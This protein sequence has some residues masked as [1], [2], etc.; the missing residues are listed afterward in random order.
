M[1]RLLL[2][3]VL[4]S[5]CGASSLAA[6]ASDPL[7]ARR[8]VDTANDEV[9]MPEADDSSTAATLAD[10]SSPLVL[11]LSLYVV[12]D[13]DGGER[14]QRSSARTVE[15]VE[16]I[17][18]RIREIW[19][20]AGVSFDPVRVSTIT[21]PG[22]VI[23]DLIAGD[24]RP[25]IAGAGQSFAVPDAGVING[26]YVPF[27][28]GANGFT[29]LGSRIFFVTD[30]PS[31]HDERVS[32]HEIGHILG[33]H[34]VVDDATRLMFSGTNGTA[35]TPTETTVARYGAAGILDRVR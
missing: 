5:S 31:V 13:A 10:D 25:F 2:L 3:A 16:E 21:V 24:A 6:P 23:D 22:G 27:V 26:F 15:G 30:R 11:S 7:P 33:L 34:H 17:A 14:S 12:Q 20:A 1:Y 19:S 9:A 28:G 4:A 32:S 18:A 29:P 35:I 8:E